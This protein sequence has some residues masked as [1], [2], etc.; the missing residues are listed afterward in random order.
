MI[1]YILILSLCFIS[2]AT[3]QNINLKVEISGFNNDNGQG[4]IALYNS[5]KDFLKKPFKGRV[6][7]IENGK[8]T[9][10]FTDIPKSEYAVSTFHDE[11]NNGKMDSNFLG[12]PKE[13]YG[14][15]NDA[16]GFM[17]APKYTNAK[18]YVTESKTV[19]IH[20]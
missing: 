2:K 19:Y 14:F 8:T 6:V 17:S 13:D 18:M 10:V 9:I 3:A 1:K 7:K 12:I 16:K 11:N 15:S 5:E 4:Y 20:I